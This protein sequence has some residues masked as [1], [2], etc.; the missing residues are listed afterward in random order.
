MINILLKELQLSFLNKRMLISSIFIVLLMIVNSLTFLKN[1]SQS[2]DECNSIIQKNKEN[3]EVNSEKLLEIEKIAKIQKIGKEIIDQYSKTKLSDLIFTEQNIIKPPSNLSFISTNH[4]NIPNGLKMDY[5]KISNPIAYNF[6]S[7]STKHFISLDWTNIILY[8]LSFIC[9]C[10][11]YNSFSGEKMGGTLKL[12]LSNPI[13]RWKIIFGKFFSLCIFLLI[14][15]LTGI[16]ISIVIFNISTVIT[17][18]LVDYVKIAY[19]TI[20]TVLFIALN[21]LLFLTISVRT[22][23][24]QVSLSISLLVWAIFVIILPNI[25]GVIAQKIIIVPSQ[26]NLA[27]K[28]DKQ[29]QESGLIKKLGWWNGS[30]E[31]KA[32]VDGVF[33]WKMKCD[34]KDALHRE[35]WEN[36]RNKMFSQTQLAINLS[37]I[38][39]FSIY[40]FFND[41]IAD[42]N[43][44]GYMNFYKQAKDYQNQFQAFVKENDM[45]DKN[46]FHLIWNDIDKCQFFMSKK[47][48]N[49]HEF[50]M[51]KYQTSLSLNKVIGDCLSELIL[52]IS[53]I[54]FLFIILYFSFIKYDVR[55]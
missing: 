38:S 10:L 48:I 55:S 49:A 43:L 24:P 5:F 42:N 46:S 50:P 32:P 52:L 31:K 1:Q 19:F 51:F 44:Y 29:V 40:R 15:V 8:L 33:Q 26:S 34:L 12:L 6:P 41:K 17:L 28:E 27:T 36:Y 20:V 47:T 39:P 54:I 9:L 22:S 16:L 25:S 53:W 3:I 2:I 21:V 4:E 45:S 35:I 14:P 7:T 30:W 11:S 23:K 13:P 18:S 37:Q